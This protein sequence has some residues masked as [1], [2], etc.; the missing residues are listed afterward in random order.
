MIVPDT[1]IKKSTIQQLQ[2]QLDR[3]GFIVTWSTYD[4]S[5]GSVFVMD[6]PPDPLHEVKF[7]IIAPSNYEEWKEKAAER[8]VDT[9][10]PSHEIFNF[11]RVVSE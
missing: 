1:E 4:R 11:Y 9:F 5:I 6:N 3:D 8:G 2:R 10:L 7:K